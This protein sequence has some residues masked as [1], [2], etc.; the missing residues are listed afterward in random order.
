M[1]QTVNTALYMDQECQLS[2]MCN[3]PVPKPRSN[4]LLVKVA[5]SGI[6]PADTRRGVLLGIRPAVMGYDFSVGRPARYGTHQEYLA[7]P[8]D[9]AFLVPD[10]LL[11]PDAA[12][13]TVV[14]C[15]AANALLNTFSLPLPLGNDVQQQQPQQQDDGGPLL[16]WG[17]ATAVGCCAIQYARASGVKSVLVTASPSP[18][19]LLRGFGATPCFDYRAPQVTAQIAAAVKELA[20]GPIRFALDA[21][22]QHAA[23]DDSSGT[24]EPVKACLASA[25]TPICSVTSMDP[26]VPMPLPAWA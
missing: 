15:T 24:V 4:E 22:G 21:A 2:A 19:E 5:F 16:I 1:A 18:H 9:W 3:F 25:D 13:L 6:N 26:R 12:C 20:A 14:A 8:V 10:N 23:G 7:C 11:L 17:G